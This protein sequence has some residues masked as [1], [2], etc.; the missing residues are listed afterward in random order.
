MILL[1]HE[2]DIFPRVPARV[3]LTLSG[4]THGGQVRLLGYSPMVPSR[5]GNRYAYGHIVE[6][7][8]H[9]SCRAGSAARSCPCASACRRR[10][11]WSMSQPPDAPADRRWPDL[12]G[13]LVEDAGGRRHVLPVRV[14]FEDTDFSGLVYHAHLPALV[15]ARPLRLPAPA[16][17]RPSGADRRRR[18]P[19]A[20]GLRGAAHGARISS[21]PRASTRC[22]R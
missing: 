17:Q 1:A 13:R 20:R 15:R 18:G 12:A 22:W 14:Y 10:S 11:S 6:D 9:S 2:P 4:H 5:Y 21:S 7:N 8:R 16:R 3:A 19:R